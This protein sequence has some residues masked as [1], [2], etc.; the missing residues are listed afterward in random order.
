MVRTNQSP[1]IFTERE[2]MQFEAEHQ[3]H[4]RAAL[5]A[6]PMAAVT[7]LLVL[8]LIFSGGVEYALSYEIFAYLKAPLPGEI[9]PWSVALF[10]MTGVL[11]ALAFHLYASEHPNVP[12]VRLLQ[13][14]VN[15]LVPLY[16]LG[17]GLALA[18]I[19]YFDG[20]DALF[21]APSAASMELFSAAAEESGSP[22]LEKLVAN[23]ALV[24]VLGCGGLAIITLYIFHKLASIITRNIRSLAQTAF[25][26]RTAREAMKT[27][28]ECDREYASLSRQHEELSAHDPRISEL[29]FA[30]SI[31]AFI[32][33]ELISIEERHL[34]H[35]F[36]IKA[37]ECRFLPHDES[38]SVDLKAIER[39]VAAIRAIDAKT[40]TAAFHPDTNSRSK[41]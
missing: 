22:L 20:A 8:G 21:K 40:I 12:A 31:A 32:Q 37:P 7:V 30:S 6:L 19:L 10:A 3:R 17:A 5:M 16:A 9:A 33:A 14:S 23:F 18:A 11:M 34:P 28:R 41:P 25:T 39:R 13:L 1:S 4:M 26:F 36:K 2:L 35:Q 24:F 15:I 38:S 29:S 27:I